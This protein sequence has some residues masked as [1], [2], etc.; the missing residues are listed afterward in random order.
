[1]PPLLIAHK[2]L[3]EAEVVGYLECRTPRIRIGACSSASNSNANGKHSHQAPAALQAG[4]VLH[5]SLRM[6]LGM[7]DRVDW[8]TNS[9]RA[10]AVSNRE[11]T[12]VAA[13]E[14]II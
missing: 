2:L 13:A 3:R 8:L 12:N 1:M 6:K 9:S 11:R 4:G 14:C 5:L 7:R 10:S